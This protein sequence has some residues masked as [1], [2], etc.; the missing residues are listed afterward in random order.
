MEQVQT[1]WDGGQMT[2]T[3]PQAQ[4]LRLRSRCGHGGLLLVEVRGP[5][6][7]ALL[8]ATPALGIPEATALPPCSWAGPYDSFYTV[9]QNGSDMSLLGQSF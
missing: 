9:D 5:L 8:W 4:G 3:G 6:E 2:K 7:L 1:G